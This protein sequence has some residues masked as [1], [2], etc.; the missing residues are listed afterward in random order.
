MWQPKKLGID[1]SKGHIV[2]HGN[3]PKTPARPQSAREADSGYRYPAGRG[4]RSAAGY[5][6]NRICA[7][8]WSEG[9]IGASGETLSEAPQGD[10]GQGRESALGR[11]K[12]KVL[13][14]PSLLAT[15]RGKNPDPRQRSGAKPLTV[16][17]AIRSQAAIFLVSDR[18]IT[19]GDI[20][21]EPPSEKIIFL[22]SCIAVMAAGDSAFHHE[23][24]KDVTKTV[25]DRVSK[26]PDNWWL[27]KDV[28]DLYVNARNNAKLKRAE[29]ALLAPLGLNRDTFLEKQKTMDSDLVAS[30]ARDLI[31]FEVPGVSIIVAGLD[32]LMGQDGPNTHIYSIFD[33]EVSCDDL[34][35][36][37]A[38]GSGARHAES[39]IMLNRHAWNTQISDALLTAYCAKKN[40]EIAP[41]VGVE[42]DLFMVGPDIGQNTRLNSEVM[43]KVDK[44]YRAITKKQTKSVADAKAELQ[45]YVESLSSE[46]TPQADRP[47][48]QDATKSITGPSET[49]SAQKES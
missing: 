40:S 10:C 39:Y 34:I 47:A 5:G 22:T 24:M 30:I 17:I 31:N 43:S 49:K 27:V 12:E 13:A 9:R 26:E 28:V 11:A 15:K 2:G 29:A 1:R 4:S 33:G 32:R 38:I 3:A 48:P 45:R 44:E 19:S 14:E 8:W 18:M 46:A 6:S 21:F 37:R 7:D 23:V 16:C 41:G 20:Q 25:V 36:F 35:G 42:T